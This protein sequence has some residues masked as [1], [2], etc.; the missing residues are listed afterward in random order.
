MRTVSDEDLLHRWTGAAERL[1]AQYSVWVEG[2]R[3]IAAYAKPARRYHGIEHLR[4]VLDHVDTLERFAHDADVV[5]V[6]A[7]FHDAVH[8]PTRDDNEHASAALAETVLDRMDVED[9]TIAEVSRLV[10]LTATHDPDPDDR[11]GIV[12]CDA[13]L[14]V[15]GGTPDEY[16]AYAAAIRLEFAH[17]PTE[18]FA[19]ARADVLKVLLRRPRIYRSPAARTAWEERA[20]TNLEREIAFLAE[21]LDAGAKNVTLPQEPPRATDRIDDDAVPTP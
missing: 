6:A 7:W 5:R 1:G 11:D 20:R 14:A 15:L 12:L 9:D 21:S 3:L 13:D 10:R 17:V 2:E 16:T 18:D 8:D 4:A 19:V